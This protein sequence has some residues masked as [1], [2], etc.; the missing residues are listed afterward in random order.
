MDF[1]LFMN[2]TDRVTTATLTWLVSSP[3][4]LLTKSLSAVASKIFNEKLSYSKNKI[5]MDYIEFKKFIEN[6]KKSYL[7]GFLIARIY[8]TLITLF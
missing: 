8:Y 4:A 2:L 3:F 1:I 6:L 7:G 5:F